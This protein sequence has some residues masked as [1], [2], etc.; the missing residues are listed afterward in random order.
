MVLMGAAATG[1]LRAPIA[2][3]FDVR[4]VLL[5][6]H[7]WVGAC[8]ALVTIVAVVRRHRLRVLATG[9][10]VLTAVSGWW[11]TRMLSPIAGAL[12]AA[13]GATATVS[14]A[15]ALAVSAPLSASARDAAWVRRVAQTGLA[16]MVLQVAVGAMLRHQLVTVEWHMLTGGLGVLMVLVAAGAVVY[17]A[18]APES[19]RRAAR[20]TIAVTL[21]QVALGA[22]VFVL[23][24]MGAPS[25]SAWLA[26]TIAHVTGGT[27]TMLVLLAFIVALRSAD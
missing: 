21:A 4:R 9:L 1:L 24:V 2:A 7:E 14:V 25:T 12:H 10:I 18:D 22:T 26:S 23:I 17:N 20:W 19:H 13:A 3:S 8:L 27:V 15:A 6:A 11:S 16:L 5:V